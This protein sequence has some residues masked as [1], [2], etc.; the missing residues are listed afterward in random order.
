[1]N[2]RQF[3]TVLGS[4]FIGISLPWKSVPDPITQTPRSAV[5]SSKDEVTLIFEGGTIDFSDSRQTAA[6]AK[7]I[8]DLQ[9]RRVIIRRL[10]WG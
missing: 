1:M 2:R 6:F 8:E 10:Y 7:A 4:I 3:A 9:R 5:P